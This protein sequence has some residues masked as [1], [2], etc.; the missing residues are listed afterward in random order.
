MASAKRVVVELT[1]QTVANW[2]EWGV[3]QNR[4]YLCPLCFAVLSTKFKNFVD[5]LD[6]N[7]SL[8]AD[9]SATIVLSH[10]ECTLFL[11]STLSAPHSFWVHTVFELLFRCTIRIE[12]TYFWVPLW[13]AHIVLDVFSSADCFWVLL[14]SDLT[15]LKFECVLKFWKVFKKENLA[16]CFLSCSSNA[17][18]TILVHILLSCQLSAHII[19]NVLSSTHWFELYFFECTPV[20]FGKHLIWMCFEILKSVQKAQLFLIQS[21]S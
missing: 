18:Y 14:L 2:A 5:T 11:S 7:L 4:G 17:P 16:R 12:C 9:L 19:L 21:V 3:V 10:F 6:S 20:R 1:F 13:S 8:V 15:D